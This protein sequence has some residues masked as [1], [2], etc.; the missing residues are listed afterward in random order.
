MHWFPV[1]QEK[2]ALW[3]ESPVFI[4]AHGP[5]PSDFFYGFPSLPGSN[6]VKTAG[7]QYDTATEPDNV[8]RSVD[9]AE[10]HHVYDTH[11]KGRLAGLRP[12]AV[13][14]VTC[15]YTVS[16]DSNFLIDWHPES[17]RI[18]VVSPCSGHG[19]KHSAAIGEVAAQVAVEGRSRI[20]VSAFALARFGTRKR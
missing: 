6:S 11:L 9:P 12:V 14:A 15:L 19:F 17:E 18:L 1:E 20:D 10:S 3:T 13:K 8:Q 2:A 5:E 4:W 16:P 7:E